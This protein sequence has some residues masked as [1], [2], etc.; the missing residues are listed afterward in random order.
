M[1]SPEGILVRPRLALHL[2]LTV[3][4]P[5]LSHPLGFAALLLTGHGT[6]LISG[7]CALWAT[8]SL[9]GVVRTELHS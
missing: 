1:L 7:V 4:S 3:T 9:L 2:R 5:M 8:W 6:L